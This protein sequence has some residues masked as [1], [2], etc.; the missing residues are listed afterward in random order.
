MVGRRRLAGL[1]AHNRLVFRAFRRTDAGE[2][3]AIEGNCRC[4]TRL[5]AS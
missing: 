4:P 3:E 1:I 5:T 2:D